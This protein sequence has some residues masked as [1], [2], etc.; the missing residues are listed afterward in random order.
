ML[1]GLTK[2]DTLLAFFVSFILNMIIYGD[3]KKAL[4]FSLCFVFIFLICL[5]II[6]T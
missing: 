4:L 5:E 2:L 3:I 1:K 6:K